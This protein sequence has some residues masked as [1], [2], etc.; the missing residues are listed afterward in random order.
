MAT[1]RRSGS[2]SALVETGVRPGLEGGDQ[3][4]LAGAVET[5]G[6][7]PVQDVAR[8]DR[9][10]S[11]DLGAELLGPLVLERAH[12]GLAGQQGLPGRGDVA[13]DG[14]RGPESGD[15]DSSAAHLVHL[16]A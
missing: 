4:E 11:R 14:G 8:L 2:T 6:L 12:S 15:D 9:D 7:D 10:L 5:A 16:V 3:R 13:A 1:A